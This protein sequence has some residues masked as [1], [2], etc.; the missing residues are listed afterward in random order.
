MLE[1][2]ENTMARIEKA[3]VI[4]A[5]VVMLISIFLQV[6]FRA[7]GWPLLGTVDIGLLSICVLTFIGFGLAVYTKDHI[8]IEVTDLLRSPRLRKVIHFLSEILM[9]TFSV[10]LISIVYPFFTYIAE[11]G[12]KTIELGIPIMLPIG[13]LVIGAGLAIFHGVIQLLLMIREMRP[14][15][16]MR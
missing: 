14:T 7:F 9:L 1:R 2:I 6:C 16:E 4:I 3:V 12:E 5:F 13:A 8:T 15:A 11:S 10:A